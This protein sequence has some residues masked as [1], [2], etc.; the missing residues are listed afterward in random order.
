MKVNNLKL[1]LNIRYISV[2]TERYTF[3]TQLDN[4]RIENDYAAAMQIR[5]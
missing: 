3:T 4:G 2:T 5:Q 1:E